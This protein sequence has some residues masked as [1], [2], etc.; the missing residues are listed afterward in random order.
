MAER[1]TITLRRIGVKDVRRISVNANECSFYVIEVEGVIYRRDI[2]F[3]THFI[4]ISPRPIKDF[5]EV[6]G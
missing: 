4:E 3:E 2:N 1:T 5:Q 6:Q